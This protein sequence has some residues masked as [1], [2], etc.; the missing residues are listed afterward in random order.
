[1]NTCY[2]ANPCWESG[3]TLQLSHRSQEFIGLAHIM[4]QQH[5]HFSRESFLGNPDRVGL[6]FI[7]YPSD[8]HPNHMLLFTCSKLQKLTHLPKVQNQT[9]HS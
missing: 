6:M 5:G 8:A 3:T 7:I 2:L 9:E 1:M 4:D